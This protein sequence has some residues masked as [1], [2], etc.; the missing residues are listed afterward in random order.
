M[1]V[2]CSLWAEWII[3]IFIY[4]CSQTFKTA[5]FQKEINADTN[6]YKH[7]PLPL[8]NI[9]VRTPHSGYKRVPSYKG[10]PII[11]KVDIAVIR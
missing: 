8:Y 2:H 5:N 7:F 9:D 1:C 3:L 4:S 11:R 6:I 10:H